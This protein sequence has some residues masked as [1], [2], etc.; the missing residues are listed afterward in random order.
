MTLGG[1]ERRWIPPGAFGEDTSNVG[2]G[3]L[4]VS[5]DHGEHFTNISGNLPDIAANWTAF[6]NGQLVVATDLGVYI[7]DAAAGTGS[8]PAYSVLGTGLPLA[9]VFTCASARRTPTSAGRDLRPR[10]LAVRL[11]LLLRGRGRRRRWWRRRWRH[12]EALS[13]AVR[14]ALG[15]ASGPAGAWL[16][17]RSGSASAA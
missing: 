3:H 5:H 11:R 10:R 8:P 13:G 2:V 6:H 16:H 17:S 1:Y 4:F 14:E 7:S 12:R 9:P 15:H